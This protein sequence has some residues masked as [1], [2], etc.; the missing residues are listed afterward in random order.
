VTA[1]LAE[2]PLCDGGITL[3]AENVE[4][5]AGTIIGRNVV[6]SASV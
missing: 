1:M 3:V 2:S 6:V 4:V 5:S